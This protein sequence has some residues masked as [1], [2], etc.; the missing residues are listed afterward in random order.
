MRDHSKEHQENADRKYSYAFD[1]VMHRFMLRALRPFLPAGKALELGCYKGDVT[2]LL[3]A[4]FSDLT[5]VEAAPELVE[6][7]SLRVGAGVKF[8]TSTFEALELDERYDAIF[9]MHTLEHLD[10][11]VAV[12]KKVRSWLSATGLLFLVV[13]NGN[14]PSRQIAVKMG[15]ISHNTAVTVAEAAH[16]HRRTYTFD[17]LERDAVGAGL[18]PV[19]RGGVFFKGLA[20]FQF[21]QAI[22]AGIVS[23]EYLEGCYKLGMQYP[24]LCASIYLVCGRGDAAP[25][26]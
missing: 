21:D 6:A 14:A 5:V 9:L 4:H 26:T 13:P 11:A 17:T 24:D 18:E 19:H 20:N 8:I 22:K 10:D 15:L 1:D 7:A 2:H 23:D 16:G 25:T 3:K 12:L